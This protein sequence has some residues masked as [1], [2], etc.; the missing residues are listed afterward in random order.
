MHLRRD[1]RTR[2]DRARSRLEAFEAQLHSAT[3]AYLSWAFEREQSNRKDFFHALNDIH[4]AM[5][6]VQAERVLIKVFDFLGKYFLLPTRN[7]LTA[8]KVQ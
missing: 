3:D 1:Y 5:Q 8:W 6:G 2:H 4:A 7:I